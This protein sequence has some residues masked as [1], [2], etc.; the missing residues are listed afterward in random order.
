[1]RD[2]LAESISAPMTALEPSLAQTAFVL[3]ARIDACEEDRT[4]S[5]LT[6]ELRATLE[7]IAAARRGMEP[8]DRHNDEVAP[9]DR[10][11]LRSPE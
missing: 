2:D 11:D 4:L 9:D 6:K 8:P 1:V 5:A 10:A 7:Q 3:A